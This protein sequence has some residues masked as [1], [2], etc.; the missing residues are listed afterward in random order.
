[1]FPYR[2]KEFK[3]IVEKAEEG[4]EIFCIKGMVNETEEIEEMIRGIFT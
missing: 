2:E 4:N 3:E 1:M